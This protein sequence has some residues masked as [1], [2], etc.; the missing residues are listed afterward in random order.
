MDLQKERAAFEAWLF[1]YYPKSELGVVY[2]PNENLY[3][4]RQ[5]QIRWIVWQAA[6]AQMVP[7]NNTT[8]V[9]VERMVEQQ[10]K[11]SGITAD[12]FRLDGEEILN[13]AVEAARGGK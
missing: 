4:H 5:T 12:V 11:A 3:E 7:I 9:A 2:R 1:K 6:K 13:A 8:I 10:V